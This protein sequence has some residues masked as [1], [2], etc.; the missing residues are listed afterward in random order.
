MKTST[1]IINKVKER[2]EELKDKDFEWKSF[3]KLRS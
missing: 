2:F 1:E 3:Y